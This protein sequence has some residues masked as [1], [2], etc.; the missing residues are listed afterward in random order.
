MSLCGC[1][2]TQSRGGEGKHGPKQPGETRKT[3][4]PKECVPGCDPPLAGRNKPVSSPPTGCLLTCDYGLEACL[5]LSK[6][7]LYRPVNA[8]FVGQE[9]GSSH[10]NRSPLT[11]KQRYR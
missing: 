8:Q 6:A 9:I 3:P 7:L 4:Q 1:V 11:G 10:G 2:P 5:V